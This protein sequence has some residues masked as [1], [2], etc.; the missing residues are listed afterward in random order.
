MNFL[1]FLRG[2]KQGSTRELEAAISDLES[3]IRRTDDEMAEAKKFLDESYLRT[4][5]GGEASPD[6]KKMR[7]RLNDLTQKRQTALGA[8]GGVARKTSERSHGRS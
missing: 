6:V 5:A 7:D 8:I 3:E 4:L 1:S 2:E